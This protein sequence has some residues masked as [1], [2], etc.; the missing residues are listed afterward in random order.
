MVA[1]H[2]GYAAELGERNQM[3]KIKEM[4]GKLSSGALVQKSICDA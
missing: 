3:R 4:G 2:M 1:F